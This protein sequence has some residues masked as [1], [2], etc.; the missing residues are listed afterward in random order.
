VIPVADRKEVP[1]FTA[2]SVKQN[3]PHVR[4]T[5]H[6]LE[7]MLTLRVH[8]DDCPQDNGALKVI[9]GSHSNGILNDDQINE[10][11][12]RVPPVICEALR[13]DVLVMRPLLLHAS[14][15]ANAPSH[16]R[17]IHLEYAAEPLPGGLEWPLGN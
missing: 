14:S 17:V 1:G 8:L 7:G 13:S 5:E 2:W 15:P 16:R 12:S 10:V 11:I 6:V 4:P 3:V 9:P